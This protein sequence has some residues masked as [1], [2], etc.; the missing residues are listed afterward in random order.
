MLNLSNTALCELEIALP[1]L[2]CQNNHVASMSEISAHIMT[3]QE[4]ANSKIAALAE[5]K[6]SLLQKAFAGELT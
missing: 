2:V 1:S 6:Q 5:L 4:R 3:L